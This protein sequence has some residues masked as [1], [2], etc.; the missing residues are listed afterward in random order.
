M[1]GFGRTLKYG[2]THRSEVLAQFD[3]GHRREHTLR[4]KMETA[5]PEGIDVAPDQE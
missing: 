2:Y 5:V 4:I 3:H 1:S